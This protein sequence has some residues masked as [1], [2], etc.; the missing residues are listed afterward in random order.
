VIMRKDDAHGIVLYG[1]IKYFPGMHN[2][3]IN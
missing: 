3:P 1:R 2:G